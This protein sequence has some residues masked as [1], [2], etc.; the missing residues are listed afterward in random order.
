MKNHWSK[1]AGESCFNVFRGAH[2]RVTAGGDSRGYVSTE[3]LFLRFMS[4][5]QAPQ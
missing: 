3:V 1:V 4:S 2:R 5:A